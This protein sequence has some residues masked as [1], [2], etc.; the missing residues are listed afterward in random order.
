MRAPW[1]G[2]RSWSVV[3]MARRS[4]RRYV[5][6]DLDVLDPSHFPHVCVPEGGGLS[7][8]ALLEIGA[9]LARQCHHSAVVPRQ[10]AR[11][12]DVKSA[13]AH[14]YELFVTA[15]SILRVEV[16]RGLGTSRPRALSTA[17]SALMVGW[18]GAGVGLL[19]SA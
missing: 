11:L 13:R 7:P 10:H 16:L 19:G 12:T 18:L 6:L 15:L 14:A 5:H 3:V 9:Q 4:L 8:G 2:G 17:V 1:G